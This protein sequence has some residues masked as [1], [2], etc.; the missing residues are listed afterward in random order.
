MVYI[1]LVFLGILSS[2]C[3]IYPNMH[4]LTCKTTNTNSLYIYRNICFKI[5]VKIIKKCLFKLV[6][7]NE[8][9][10]INKNDFN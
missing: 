10:N 1:Y 4:L 2:L 7:F 5:P 3:T 6:S 8:I 9:N